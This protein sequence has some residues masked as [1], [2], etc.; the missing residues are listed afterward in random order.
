MN[1]VEN[2]SLFGTVQRFCMKT[3][4]SLRKPIVFIGLPGFL[5]G[6]LKALVENPAPGGCPRIPPAGS[7]D[8]PSQVPQAQDS[9]P[10]ISS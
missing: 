7:P 5:T 1:L 6:C 8:P 4:I 3:M 2:I 10:K 9:K